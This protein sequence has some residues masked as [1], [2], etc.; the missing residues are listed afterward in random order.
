LNGWLTYFSENARNQSLASADCQ[1]EWTLSGTAKKIPGAK[2]LMEYGTKPHQI[3][4]WDT[5]DLGTLSR[6]IDK[7]H[8]QVRAWDEYPR[9]NVDRS[10]STYQKKLDFCTQCMR[11]VGR[12]SFMPDLFPHMICV[13]A[14]ILQI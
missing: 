1:F 2:D 12:L 6:A 11:L 10:R 7:G 13:A 3:A 4:Q 14:N 9:S 5:L 8:V